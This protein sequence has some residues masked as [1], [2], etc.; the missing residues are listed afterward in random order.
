MYNLFEDYDFFDADTAQFLIERY[1][2]QIIDFNPD[3]APDT[4]LLEISVA[5]YDSTNVLGNTRFYGSHNGD[6][7]IEI[8]ISKYIM[9]NGLEDLFENTFVHEYCHYLANL[10]MM[11]DNRVK[12]TNKATFESKEVEDYYRADEGH[13]ECWLKYA[14]MLSKALNLKFKITPHPQE[15]ENQLYHSANYNEITCIIKCPNNDIP[16]VYLYEKDPQSI[17]AHDIESAKL[18]A[19]VIMHDVCCR[20]CKSELVIEF[21]DPSIRNN[22][23]DELRQIITDIALMSFFGKL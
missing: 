9:K 22:Y 20:L 13:G 19:G 16:A 3:F 17:F 11:N 7:H 2:K 8:S 15:P 4:S 5:G 18:V 14:D 21:T 1:L 6:F 10:E 12:L 23:L